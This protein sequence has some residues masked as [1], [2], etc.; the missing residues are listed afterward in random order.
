MMRCYSELIKL[1]TFKER[2]EYLKLDGRVG[3]ETFGYD[4]YLNQAFYHSDEW[5]SI[6][7]RVILRDEGCDLGMMDHELYGKIY[8]HHM[9]PIKADD[10]IHASDYLTNPEYLICC[11]HNTHNAIHY[12]DETLLITAPVERTPFDMCPWKK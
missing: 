5:Q 11:S 2:F 12:G 3:E 6:R 10:I 1:P 9:N 8:I 4:R 7:N